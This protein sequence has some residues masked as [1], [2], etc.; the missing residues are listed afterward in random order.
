MDAGYIF[1]ILAP[2]AIHVDYF[3]QEIRSAMSFMEIEK[4]KEMGL[5]G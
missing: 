1:K 4:V 3:Q 2:I 5:G